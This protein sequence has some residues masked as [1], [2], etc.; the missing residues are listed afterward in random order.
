[1]FWSKIWLFIV[2]AVAAVAIT[3]ALLLPRP[4]QRARVLEER[5]RLVVACDMVNILL[6][7]NARV[8]VEVAGAFART[9]SVVTTLAEASGVATID[10]RRASNARDV[11]EKTIASVEGARPDFAILLDKRGRVVARKGLDEAE[12][13]DT[14]AGRFVVDDALAG[15]LRDDLWFAGGRLYRI[16]ASPVVKLDA[17]VEYVGAVL[18]GNAVNRDFAAELVKP[19]GAK[20]SFYAEGQVAAA[21]TDTVLDRE[22]L[23]EYARLAP[24]KGDLAEDCRVV[25]PFSSRSGPAEFS[26]LVARLPGEARHDDAFFTVF[27]E[28]GK[29][30]GMAATLDAVRKDDLS[31]GHFPWLLV[32]LGFL[33]ALG[34][35]LTLMILETDRPLRRL[36]ADAVKLAKGEVERVPEERHGGRM[37]SIAR[38][39]NIQIDKLAREARAA[40]RDLDQ[41]LGPGPEGSGSIGGGGLGTL[42]LGG[43]MPPSRPGDSLPKAPAAPAEFRFNDPL[44]PPEL[45]LSPSRPAGGSSAPPAPRAI[46]PPP[47]PRPPPGMPGTP[48]L[49]TPTP[50][51]GVPRPPAGRA[52]DDDI[53]TDEA[54]SV[55][56]VPDGATGDDAELRRVYEEFVELKQR[57]GEPTSG[58]TFAKF[59]DKLRKNR[60]ELMAKPGTVAVKFSVYVKDGKAALKATPVKEG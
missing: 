33:G 23:D 15:Y 29:A 49:R 53:L 55:T 60:D 42:D 54:S 14:M 45:D 43:P 25:K 16:A 34:I 24:S 31:F 8:Q 6:R 20:I 9:P 52:L 40:R 44:P 22:L 28:R 51:P 59:G 13:G 19:L 2:A 50:A 17:P 26:A 30:L 27:L 36:A 47:R 48:P 1:M 56:G 41:L 18:I 57:C 10:D 38:S 32:G 11:A 3:V 4:A 21:S 58:V 39:V 5:E 46:T 37:G 12:F 35:G 7:S